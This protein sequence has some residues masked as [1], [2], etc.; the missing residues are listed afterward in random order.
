MQC[1]EDEAGEY[2]CEN[3]C[4]PFFLH[5]KLEPVSTTT[6]WLHYLLRSRR[7]LFHQ[8]KQLPLK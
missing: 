5:V 6:V 3:I 2:L 7:A 4:L 8:G 1:S